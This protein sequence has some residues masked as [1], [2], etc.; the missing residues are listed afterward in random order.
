[1]ARVAPPSA[2]PAAAPP[3]AAP[4]S[5][6]PAAAKVKK[7]K[8]KKKDLPLHPALEPNAEG[9]PTK[10]LDTWPAD[11]DAA[12]H[13]PLKRGH[14]SSESVFL[15]A[16]AERL[17]HQAKEL[18]QEAADVKAGK[19]GKGKT[20]KLLKMLKRTEELRKELE[21]TGLNVDALLEAARA[22]QAE[23]DAKAAEK[24]ETAAA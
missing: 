4:G 15:I 8:G 7:A 10:R 9:K 11:F 6:A 13:R 19:P 14:F 17:E 20:G 5:A 23:K 18:R 2:A 3:S 22:A 1:M 21:A 16:K 24:S 12:K